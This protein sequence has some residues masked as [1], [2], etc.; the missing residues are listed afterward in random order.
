MAKELMMTDLVDVLEKAEKEANKAATNY[1]N[2]VL[3]GK[4]SFPCGFAWVDI[5]SYNGVKITGNTK[6][7]KLLKR[8][9][10]EQNYGDRKFQLWMPGRVRA[11][12]VD[13]A[14]AGCQGAAMV[15]EDAGFE[16][17]YGSRWD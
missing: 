13:V 6:V 11:Q 1:L 8:A 9:G 15:L 12:N 2:D 5:K 17:D 14:V 10:V 3:K 4:D 16:V 7:G